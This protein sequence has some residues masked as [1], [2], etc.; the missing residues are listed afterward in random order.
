MR[1]QRPVLFSSKLPVR[2]EGNLAQLSKTHC[3]LAVRL[4][5]H[6]WQSPCFRDTQLG[7]VWSNQERAK[8]AE[9]RGDKD[10]E[11]GKT[12]GTQRKTQRRGRHACDLSGSGI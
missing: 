8:G 5:N 11:G 2:G 6:L 9:G 7:F 3:V 12:E 10:R 1:E 4:K